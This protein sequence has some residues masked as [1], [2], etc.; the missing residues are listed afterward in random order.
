MKLETDS[1]AVQMV[2]VHSAK[3]LEYPV[4]FCPFLWSIRSKKERRK[5]RAVLFRTSKEWCVDVGSAGFEKSLTT[6]IEQ[7]DEEE[8]RKLY[9][10]LTRARHRLYIGFAPVGESA[11][12]QNGAARSPLAALPGLGLVDTELSS[13]RARLE[14]IEGLAL[15]SRGPDNASAA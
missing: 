12:N 3:G 7:E 1:A 15:Q 4:V 2:T 10:A 9:V 11:G 14:Q 6:G 5:K 13:W 8:Y